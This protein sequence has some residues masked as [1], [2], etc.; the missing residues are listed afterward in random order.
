MQLYLSEVGAVGDEEHHMDVV[1]CK[2]RLKDLV[3]MAGRAV[4]N[5]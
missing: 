4:E 3:G 1:S 2:E 5:Q